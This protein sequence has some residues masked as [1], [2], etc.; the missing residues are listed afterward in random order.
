MKKVLHVEHRKDLNTLFA[1]VTLQIWLLYL[2]RVA[3]ELNHRR[4]RS[5]SSPIIPPSET[6]M[7]YTKMFTSASRSTM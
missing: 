2:K 3:V 7:S 4:E 6:S 5:A 1:S